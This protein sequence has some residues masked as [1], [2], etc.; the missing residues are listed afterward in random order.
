MKKYLLIFLLS[1]FVYKTD[2]QTRSYM[3]RE[4]VGQSVNGPISQVPQNMSTWVKWSDDGSTITMLDGTI[5]KYQGQDYSGVHHYRYSGTSGLQMP[6][7]NYIE[8]MFSR[9][10]K[11]MQI[12]YTFGM[13]GMVTRMCSRW[14]YIGDGENNAYDW[15]DGNY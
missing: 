9:D 4:V 1:F 2:A 13:M 10:Y 11:I 15:M 5:W 3:Q 12:N 6:G 14:A 7:T 8:A